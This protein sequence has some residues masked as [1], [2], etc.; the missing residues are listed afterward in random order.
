[1]TNDTPEYPVT[2]E[3]LYKEVWQSPMLRLAEKYGVSSSYLARVCTRMNVPRPAPGYWAK[4]AVGKAPRVPALPEAK[5]EDLLEWTK[6][7]VESKPTR[8]KPRVRKVEPPKSLRKA[9]TRD[10]LPT[11]H[12]L[13]NGAKKL[14]LK[15]RKTEHKYLKPY[16][17]L[18]VDLIVSEG[19]L[20]NGLEIA[21]SLFLAL[22]SHEYRVVIAP[23]HENLRGAVVDER[24][25][26]DGQP[27]YYNHQWSPMRPTV[28]YIGNLAFGLTIYEISRSVEMMYVKG[29]Y[30]PV[31]EMTDEQKRRYTHRHHTWT[32][33]RDFASGLFVIKAYSPYSAVDW[34]LKWEIN[35]KTN[36]EKL[37][38][39]IPKQL[40]ESIG[41]VQ[42]LIEEAERQAEIRWLEWEEQK[43]KSAAEEEA[44][45]KAKALKDS[46]E[47][48]HQI[49]QNWG[50]IQTIE[51][52]F[53]EV[54][55]SA[56]S[57]SPDEQSKIED[58]LEK[59][60]ELIGFI[61]PMQ[62][63]LDWKSPEE[64]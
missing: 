11:T 62:S 16:K 30:L 46:T 49:I 23:D 59:C 56:E 31:D 3:M 41:Q 58:R 13:I 53:R 18:L 27:S 20:D 52:F 40:F 25:K 64:R 50:K 63:I 8:R 33:H 42:S 21:N 43:R 1:M 47:E 39:K 24:E 55:T 15:G 48:L 28:V 4:V 10:K 12:R 22:E 37:C 51:S 26:T 2:R 60:R 14:F 6:G 34:E 44:R 45:R 38:K 9:M 17:K 32:T 35:K 36:I 19:R 7:D 57:R 5:S 61:D 29:D 54:Q